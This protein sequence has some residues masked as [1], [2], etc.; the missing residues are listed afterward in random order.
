MKT[1]DEIHH[2]LEIGSYDVIAVMWGLLH[3]FN[4]DLTPWQ[5]AGMAHR[6]FGTDPV[7][8]RCV[9]L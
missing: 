7:L 1:K 3:D 8:S 2:V 5:S 4:S 6:S 9:H